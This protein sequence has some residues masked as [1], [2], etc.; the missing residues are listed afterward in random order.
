MNT[1]TK[2]TTGLDNLAAQASASMEQPI[3]QGTTDLDAANP[4]GQP[5]VQ[6]SP[7]KMQQI[8][9]AVSQ[10]ILGLLKV[11][12][13]AIAKRLP[14]IRE[15]WPDEILQAPAQ[16]AVPLI[17]KHMEKAMLLIGSSPELAMFAITLV[18]LGMGVF[19]AIDRASEREK[20]A[21]LEPVPESKAAPLEGGGQS[22]E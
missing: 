14:E 19:S 4:A 10:V 8:E 16:A 7:E 1:E 6:I 3:G 2:D 13:A 21:A 18:P 15:E 12:R 5:S 22:A 17:R 20:Q 9:A 11:A